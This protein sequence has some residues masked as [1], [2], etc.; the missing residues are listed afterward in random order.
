MG[1][2]TVLHQLAL[3]KMPHRNDHRLIRSGPLFSGGDLVTKINQ[4]RTQSS[5]KRPY[6]GRHAG[7]YLRVRLGKKGFGDGWMTL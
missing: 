1:Q 3:R 7:T 2:V 5:S 4:H 6:K